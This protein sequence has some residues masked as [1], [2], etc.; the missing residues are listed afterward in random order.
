M[1]TI[2]RIIRPWCYIYNSKVDLYELWLSSLLFLLGI[3]AFL[4]DPLTRTWHYSLLKEY[5][6]SS[7]LL[8]SICI[9]VSTVSIFKVFLCFKINIWVDILLKSAMFFIFTLLALSSAKFS[10]FHTISIFYCMVSILTLIII[11]KT[12]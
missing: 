2:N 9:S 3:H 7:T 5:N 4:T 8:S 10:L 6:V 12:K 1:F 11:I